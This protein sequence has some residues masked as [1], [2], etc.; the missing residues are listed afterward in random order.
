MNIAYA[1][2]L[3]LLIHHAECVMQATAIMHSNGS[4]VTNGTLMFT[5]NSAADP[6]VISGDI[7][8]L[9]ANGSHV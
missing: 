1:S 9:V 2:F 3:L 8:G 4:N 6:V 7:T 5:Q